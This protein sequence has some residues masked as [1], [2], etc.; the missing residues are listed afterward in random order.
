MMKQR[1]MIVLLPLLGVVLV[2]L[3]GFPGWLLAAGALGMSAWLLLRDRFIGTGMKFAIVG[4][5]LS[6]MGFLAYSFAAFNAQVEAADMSTTSPS[7]T[8]FLLPALI[9]VFVLFLFSAVLVLRP[10]R[11]PAGKNLAL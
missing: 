11:H 6:A 5:W 1:L 10:V 3:A 4:A 2:L 8:H 9:A 7:W